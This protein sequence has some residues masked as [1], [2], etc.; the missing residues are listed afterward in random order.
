M[1]NIFCTQK[2][3]SV[4]E[5]EAAG[6]KVQANE[7]NR[8]AL[9]QDNH[10]EEMSYEDVRRERGISCGIECTWIMLTCQ[11]SID[12]GVERQA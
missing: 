3:K 7:L 8:F 12:L 4:H 1:K 9:S 6:R 11:S 2:L 10:F 5:L